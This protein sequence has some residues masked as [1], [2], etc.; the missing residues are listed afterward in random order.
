LHIDERRHGL[1]AIEFLF[2]DRHLGGE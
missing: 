1:L 2:V